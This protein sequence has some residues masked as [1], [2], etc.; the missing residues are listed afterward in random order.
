[1]ESKASPSL[2]GFI[3]FL[4][5]QDRPALA[6]IVLALLFLSLGFTKQQRVKTSAIMSE[7]GVVSQNANKV[8]RVVYSYSVK[9]KTYVYFLDFYYTSEEQA[10]NDIKELKARIPEITLY[11]D[12]HD[13]WNCQREQGSVDHYGG[14]KFLLIV[15]MVLCIFRMDYL[16][17]L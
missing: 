4:A 11:Y 10:K 6:A 9:G 12:A 7:I 13:P 3:K 16:G 17:P 1:M 8:I 5:Y 2:I 15:G 14:F